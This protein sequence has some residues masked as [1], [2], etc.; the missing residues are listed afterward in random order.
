MRVWKYL[1]HPLTA[2][3][4]W[5][6]VPLT[7][8]FSSGAGGIVQTGTTIVT[9]GCTLQFNGGCDVLNDGAIFVDS[10]G[11]LLIT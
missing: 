9:T 2:T 6:A 4:E 7:T 8:I 1:F 3:F 5:V 11:T 10:D